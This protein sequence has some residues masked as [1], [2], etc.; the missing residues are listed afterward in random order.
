MPKVSDAHREARRAQIVEA[1]MRCFAQRGFQRTSMADIIEASGLS[2]G[3]IYLHFDSKQQIAVAAARLV[4]GHRRDEIV[5]R[6]TR[7]PLPEPDELIGVVMSGLRRELRDSRLLL[8]M[9]AEGMGEPAMG[10]VVIEIIA[11]LREQYLSYLARWGAARRGLDPDEAR[12]WAETMTP[13]LLGLSQGYI[14]QSALL[15]DFDP[16][17][18]LAGVRALFP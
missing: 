17:R 9:W 2:A 12:A 8:Q 6:L 13:M 3:A 18:Y 4:V 11:G 5:E 7:E 16:E 14:V 10:E 1:A 15:P